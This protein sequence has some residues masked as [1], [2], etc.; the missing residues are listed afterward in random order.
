MRRF[1]FRLERL[2]EIRKYKE[3]EWELKLAAITGICFT[4][5]REIEKREHEIFRSM[6]EYVQRKGIVDL[7]EQLAKEYYIGRLKLEI[8]YLKEDLKKKEEE[9]EK[10]QKR[11][12]EVS[13]ERKVLDKLK[14]KKENQYYR[15]QRGNEY[16]EL[17]DISNSRTG[18]RKIS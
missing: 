6:R 11:F 1:Q 18:R 15:Q 9:R 10:V 7:R 14:E 12:L 3:R 4:L 8:V 16:K 2:L 17:N 5:K 13:K